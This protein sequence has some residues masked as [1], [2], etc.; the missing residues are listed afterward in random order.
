MED[1]IRVWP[2]LLPPEIC[3]EIIGTFEQITTRPDMAEY[4]IDNSDQFVNSNLGRRDLGL[5]LNLPVFNRPDL[6]DAITQ[7]LQHGLMDYLNEFG[8]LRSL[9]LNNQSL[10][11]IQ[12]TRPMG[13]YHIW[14]FENGEKDYTTRELVWMFYL[15]DMPANE[16]E[17][18]FLYQCKR[19]QASQGTL[20]IWPAGMTHVHRGLTVYTQPKYIATGWFSRVFD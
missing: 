1:F 19:I 4:V 15:N 10:I 13:G 12:K 3:R 14:H 5:F 17:T 9:T 11:K 18:E 16:G 2:K 20:V 8:Q 7:Y 6:C